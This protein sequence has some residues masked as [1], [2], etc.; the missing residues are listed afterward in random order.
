MAIRTEGAPRRT[1]RDGNRPI[2]EG[3]RLAERCRLRLAV[4]V[5]Q[6]FG[7]QRVALP[8]AEI[9]PHAGAVDR[10]IV[11]PVEGVRRDLESAHPGRDGEMTQLAAGDGAGEVHLHGADTA[12]V[13]EGPVQTRHARNFESGLDAEL[14]GDGLLDRERAACRQLSI[15]GHANG[16]PGWPRLARLDPSVTDLG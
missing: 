12:A 13:V 14:G 8:A 4:N 2:D 11:P 3:D 16:A 15:D 10:G 1:Q 9:A 7:V 6:R 5:A